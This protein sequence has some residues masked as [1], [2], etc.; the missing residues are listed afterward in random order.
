M[1]R[2]SI[3]TPPTL[4]KAFS[5]PPM[6]RLAPPARISPAIFIRSPALGNNVQACTAFNS[7]LACAQKTW[8]EQRGRPRIKCY[9]GAELTM[10]DAMRQDLG[11]DGGASHASGAAWNAHDQQFTT[12]KRDLAEEIAVAIMAGKRP[13]AVVIASPADY[14]DLG[15]GFALTEGIAA[16]PQDIAG[17]SVSYETS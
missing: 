11:C 14:A 7:A 4:R 1:M 8:P 17:C 5:V 13:A 9:P 16:R 15:W 3:V 12:I 6:R 10:V 2:V